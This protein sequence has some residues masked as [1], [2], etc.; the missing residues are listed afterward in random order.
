MPGDIKYTD[1]NNDKK[2]DSYDQTYNHGFYAQNPEWVYGFG[3]N[4]EYKGFYAGIFFQGVANASINLNGGRFVPF[5]GGLTGS[6]RV[7]SV[8]HW[9]SRNP[10]NHNV[11]YPRLHPEQF[12]HNTMG[13]TW[14]YR[15][16]N[17]IRLKNLE[18]GYQ[19]NPKTLQKAL[20]KNARLYVQGNN[21]AVWDHIKMWDPEIGNKNEGVNYPLSRTFTLGLEVSF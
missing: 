21:I 11:L 7:E 19:F 14:W 5:S 12:S 9:S 3:L 8:D 15:N 13:S 17:F 18:F 4:A 1:L 2:I 10:E 6:T 20:I 16:G